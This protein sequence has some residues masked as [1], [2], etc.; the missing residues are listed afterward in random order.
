MEV[1]SFSHEYTLSKL[2]A[3]F[4]GSSALYFSVLILTFVLYM[5]FMQFVPHFRSFDYLIIHGAGLID[6]DKISKL[7]SN[8]IDKA[9]KVFNKSKNKL[10]II[11]SG[12]QG[13]DGLFSGISCLYFFLHMDMPS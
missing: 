5:I 12:G 4:I 10:L 1:Q 11:P 6:G 9:I 3:A 8:R 2:I 7:L 13:G